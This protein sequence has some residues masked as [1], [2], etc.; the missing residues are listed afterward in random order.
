MA[1]G[2][3][4][5]SIK[6]IIKKPHNIDFIEIHFRCTTRLFLLTNSTPYTKISQWSSLCSRFSNKILITLPTEVPQQFTFCNSF[7]SS[8]IVCDS[9]QTNEYFASIVCSTILPS[10]NNSK[11]TNAT[12]ESIQWFLLSL[13][14]IE[15]KWDFHMQIWPNLSANIVDFVPTL[16]QEPLNEGN[17]L[18][19]YEMQGP[20]L[21][22]LFQKHQKQFSLFT[23][24]YIGVEM[25]SR[26]EILHNQ[27]IM[28]GSLNPGKI[29]VDA[30]QDNLHQLYIT[31]FQSAEIVE[32]DPSTSK[33]K[34][35]ELRKFKRHHPFDSLSAHLGYGKTSFASLNSY[36]YDW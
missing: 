35:I 36:W 2:K 5:N 17:F 31:G 23:V 22:E 21:L 9:S 1:C 13:R 33:R 18:S 11:A 24:F 25:I 30:H 14:S 15:T 3:S 12:K 6:I 16:L 4:S 20:S 28:H 7:S 19:I 10:S 34:R 27:G 26:L 8:I 29:V 32:I